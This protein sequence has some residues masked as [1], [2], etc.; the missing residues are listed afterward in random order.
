MPPPSPSNANTYSSGVGAKLLYHGSPGCKHNF[1]S[2]SISMAFQGQNK[3]KVNLLLKWNDMP[4]S[5]MGGGWVGEKKG[6]ADNQGGKKGSARLG[7]DKNS[8]WVG[9]KIIKRKLLYSLLAA[10]ILQ[11]YINAIIKETWQTDREYREEK[12]GK[13]L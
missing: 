8:N 6:G 5:L 9:R 2:I 7:Q 12:R 3:I 10:C 4:K 11:L 13:S 1:L